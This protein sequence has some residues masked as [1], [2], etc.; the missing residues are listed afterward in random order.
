MSTG[1]VAPALTIRIPLIEKKKIRTSLI[2]V[3]NF[4]EKTLMLA[5]VEAVGPQQIVAS[6][7]HPTKLV[8]RCDIKTLSLSLE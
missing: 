3:D 6:A 2:Q 1:A 7:K 4:L 5:N 8:F